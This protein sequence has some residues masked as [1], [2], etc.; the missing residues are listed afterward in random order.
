MT[1]AKRQRTL[2][3]VLGVPRTAK[4]HQIGLAYDRFRTHQERLDA[5]PDP[6]LAAQMKVAYETLSD[7][8]KRATYDQSLELRQAE[9]RVN[10]P[11]RRTAGL[12]AGAAA[13]IA[14]AVVASMYA[15]RQREAAAA[16]PPTTEQLLAQGV[17]LTLP[18]AETRIS[19]D[20]SSEGVALATGRNEMVMPCHALAAGAQVTVGTGDTASH[21]ELARADAERDICVLRVKDPNETLAKWRTG[22]PR[23][24]E[25]VYAA[26]RD[27]PRPAQLREGRIARGI[28]DAKGGAAWQVSLPPTVPNGTPV[29]DES[30]RVVGIITT[31][32]EFGADLV[33]ALGASRIVDTLGTAAPK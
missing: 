16:A 11:A 6:R 10:H 29:L 21:A 27:G 18:V 5:V 9:R 3:D 8:G 25:K 26:V 1:D 22:D 30:G 13:L 28:P 7:P 12:I 2:Y 17:Q 24:G 33:V 31:P 20:V 4:L 15:A 19:G 32:H 14:A 23:P